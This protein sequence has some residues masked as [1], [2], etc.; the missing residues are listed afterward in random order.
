ML[1]TLGY[2]LKKKTI[3]IPFL[4]ARVDSRI[5][6]HLTLFPRLFDFNLNIRFWKPFNKNGKEK[7][8]KRRKKIWLNLVKS[9]QFE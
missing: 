3:Q 8:K 6:S 1:V 4:Q 2:S 5:G 7:E 9:S